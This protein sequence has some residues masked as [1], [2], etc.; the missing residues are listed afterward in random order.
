MAEIKIEN[1]EELEYGN[2][3]STEIET[4]TVQ[5]KLNIR[6]KPVE[7]AKIVGILEAGEIVEILGYEGKWA[8]IEKGYCM[9]Q[10]LK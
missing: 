1:I 2:E 4:A 10:Y 7:N 3:A 9:K 5:V 6:E 8:K